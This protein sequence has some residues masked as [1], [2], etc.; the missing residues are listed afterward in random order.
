MADDGESL[1]AV[2]VLM[3]G[4]SKTFSFDPAVPVA[5]AREEV[6]GARVLFRC[7]ANRPE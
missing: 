2:S 5:D 1:I 4:A 3:D 7:C 6:R